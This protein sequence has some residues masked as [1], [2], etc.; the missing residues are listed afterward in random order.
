MLRSKGLTEKV[1]LLGVDGM[2]PRFTKRLLRD[3][4][5][6]GS[7]VDGS[8]LLDS[9]EMLDLVYSHGLSPSALLKSCE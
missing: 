2:G 7:F 9:D 3:V 6:R 4:E 8:G 5:H 1:L